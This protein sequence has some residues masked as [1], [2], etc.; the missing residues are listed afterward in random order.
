MPVEA[1]KTRDQAG[2]KFA[3]HL[4][5]LV[6]AAINDMGDDFAHLK[7]LAPVGRHNISKRVFA[8]ST[9]S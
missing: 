3:A 1:R 2:T 8:S 5:K 6:I 7:R 4:E 9:G